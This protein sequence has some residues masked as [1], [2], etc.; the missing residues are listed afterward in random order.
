MR[1]P[2]NHPL[3]YVTINQKR[4]V[5]S[6]ETSDTAEIP[7][8]QPTIKSTFQKAISLEGNN[9]QYQA[10]TDSITEFLCKENVPFNV[11]IKIKP[12]KKKF[13]KVL[14][15]VAFSIPGFTIPRFLV[16]VIAL[17]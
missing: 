6:K 7:P 14:E 9:R 13:K 5:K 1:L 12:V 11:Q 2:S 17:K 10:I 4:Q 16:I 3:Q 8:S 15:I